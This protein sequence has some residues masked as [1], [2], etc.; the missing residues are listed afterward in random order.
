MSSWLN[1][2]K[3]S[4]FFTVVH[5]AKNVYNHVELFWD[6]LGDVSLLSGIHASVWLS[7]CGLHSVGLA[8]LF[9]QSAP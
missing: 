2:V 3:V 5:N 9:L 8:F 4:E 6:L 7:V 1:S